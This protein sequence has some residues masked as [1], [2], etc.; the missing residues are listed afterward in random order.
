MY[1]APSAPIVPRGFPR[2]VG[3]VGPWVWTGRVHGRRASPKL[4][5]QRLAQLPPG[6]LRGALGPSGGGHGQQY[7]NRRV[8]RA[9][10]CVRCDMVFW[11]ASEHF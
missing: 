1:I 7:D 8:A 11:G 2:G 4:A 5:P 3:R 6:V 10:S 9:C